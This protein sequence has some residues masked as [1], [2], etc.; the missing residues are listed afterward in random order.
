[1]TTLLTINVTDYKEGVLYCFNPDG[2]ASG[3]LGLRGASYP[4]IV[5]CANGDATPTGLR[6]YPSS[7]P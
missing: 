2:I 7:S 6:L 4:G 5:R 1:M 3:S